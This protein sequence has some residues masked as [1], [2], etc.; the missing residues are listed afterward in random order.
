MLFRSP[1][2][3]IK[4]ERGL[5]ANYG[6]FVDLGAFENCQNLT[7]VV[8]SDNLAYIG[9]YAFSDCASLA[10]IVIPGSVKY[11]GDD[12]FSNCSSLTEILIPNSVRK[13]DVAAFRGCSSLTSI[14][15]PVSVTK[16]GN[17]VFQG[18]QNLVNIFVDTDNKAYLDEGGVLFNKDKSVLMWYPAGKRQGKYTIPDGVIRIDHE[19]FR[20][21]KNL[22][23]IVI[24]DSV[25]EI[26]NWAFSSC[27]SLTSLSIPGGLEIT[28]FMGFSGCDNL[29]GIFVDADS[30]FLSDEDGVL[31]NKDKSV[32]MRYPKGKEQDTYVIP[33]GVTRIDD[34]AFE[35]CRN[36]K[37]VIIPNSVTKVYNRAF[38]GCESL[39]GINIPNSIEEIGFQSFNGCKDLVDIHVAPDNRKYSDVNGVLYSKN[40]SDLIRYPEEKAQGT[41]GVPGHAARIGKYAF[42]GCKNLKRVIVS[43]SVKEISD[44]A[45]FGCSSLTICTTPGSAASSYAEKHNMNCEYI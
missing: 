12:A 23:S 9:S 14:F 38:M 35:G 6:D 16:I 2:S 22:E 37:S 13:I 26:G 21:C 44:S 7:S 5:R 1:S 27:S 36:L 29:A 45:L 18:C 34:E 25:T 31:F 3:V 24:P 42:S 43:G 40:K 20:R 30:T 33:Y 17:I 8:L 11:I 4:I 15:I 41:Y 39:T 10:N 28:G 32:L 19:A